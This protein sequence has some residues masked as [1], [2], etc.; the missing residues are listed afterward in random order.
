MGKAVRT[1]GIRSFPKSVV[2]MTPCRDHM[3]ACLLRRERE[4]FVFLMSKTLKGTGKVKRSGTG[5]TDY[6][7]AQNVKGRVACIFWNYMVN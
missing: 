7:S 6:F 4:N 5:V 2:G 3:N 1:E